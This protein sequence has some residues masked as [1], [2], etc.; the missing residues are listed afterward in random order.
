M[1]DGHHVQQGVFEP[2]V[3]IDVVLL[4]AGKEGVDHSGA[5]GRFMRSG[6]K[7]VLSSQGQRADGIL[8]PVIVDQQISI[9]EVGA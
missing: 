8:H 9:V 6:E 4:A 5:F 1:I 7:I 3:R 2:L